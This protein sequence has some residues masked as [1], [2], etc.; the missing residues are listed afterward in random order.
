MS[1]CGDGNTLQLVPEQTVV[2]M[3]ATVGAD[4]EEVDVV[5][6]EPAPATPWRIAPDATA[7]PC[8]GDESQGNASGLPGTAAGGAQRTHADGRVARQGTGS[9][10][11]KTGGRKSAEAAAVKRGGRGAKKRKQAA[12]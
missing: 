3:P 9:R 5:V 10:S 6:R 7:S 12:R 1:T 4:A 11:A 8:A 2:R